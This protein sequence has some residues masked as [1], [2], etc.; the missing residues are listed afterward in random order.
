MTH[1]DGDPFNAMAADELVM[2]S[3]GICPNC[4]YRGFRL[5]PRGG[6]SI[7]IECCGCSARFNV[8]NF[9]WSIVMAHRLVSD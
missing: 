7:N 3:N 2:L 5:G 9:G 1:D 6:A 8:V 4:Q